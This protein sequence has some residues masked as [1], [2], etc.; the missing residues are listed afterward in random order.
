[1]SCHLESSRGAPLNVQ[2]TES[3]LPLLHPRLPLNLKLKLPP[4]PSDQF[5]DLPPE[6]ETPTEDE[7]LPEVEGLKASRGTLY[8]QVETFRKDSSTPLDLTAS[9]SVS[10]PLQTF[11]LS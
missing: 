8:P 5:P 2:T 9:E 7:E 10:R 11:V 6:E 3:H 1:M 4:L